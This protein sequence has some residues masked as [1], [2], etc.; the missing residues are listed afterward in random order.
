MI[1]AAGDGE[2]ELH[3]P[4]EVEEE[5]GDAEG[6]GRIAQQIEEGAKPDHGL[7]VR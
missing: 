2:G 5:G 7:P 4:V 1:P 3:R 6:G